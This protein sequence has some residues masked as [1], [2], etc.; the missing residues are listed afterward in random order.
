[1]APV[2]RAPALRV[3]LVEI[4]FET[5]THELYQLPL[6]FRPDTGLEEVIDRREGLAIYDALAVR[7]SQA[8]RRTS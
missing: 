4:G 2:L 8:R 5:G 3:A 6:G 7:S 1:M